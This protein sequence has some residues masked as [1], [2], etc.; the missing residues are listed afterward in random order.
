MLV[1]INVA[2]S[3]L[4]KVSVVMNCKIG[5]LPFLYLGLLIGGDS[6]KLRFWFPLLD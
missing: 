2:D 5:H 4:N 3:W 1:G 6:L